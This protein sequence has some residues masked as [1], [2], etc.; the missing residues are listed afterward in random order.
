MQVRLMAGAACM[1]EFRTGHYQCRLQRPEYEQ[2]GKSG[3]FPTY[4]G[5]GNRMREQTA[6]FDA[7]Y[8]ERTEY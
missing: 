3:S 7:Q 6:A 2:K 4:G 1:P 5:H 8:A